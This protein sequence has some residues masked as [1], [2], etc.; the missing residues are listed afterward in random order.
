MK[1]TIS[2]TNGC[3]LKQLSE[4]D[5]T[6]VQKLCERCGDYFC[7]HEGTPVPKNAA[8]DIFTSLPPGKAQKDKFVFGVVKPDGTLVGVIDLVQDFPETGVWMLGLMLLA[9]EER[10]NGTGRAAHEG[11]VGWAKA[12]GAKSMRIGVI[13]E[14]RA[15]AHFWDSLGYLHQEETCLKIGNANHKTNILTLQV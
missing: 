10:G 13:E 8:A 9:P 1:R 4:C 3:L 7:L 5:T 11:I 2:L 6:A 12:L 14:N 15:G